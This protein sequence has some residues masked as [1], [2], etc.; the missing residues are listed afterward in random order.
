MPKKSYRSTKHKPAAFRLRASNN[1]GRSGNK[2]P[3]RKHPQNTLIVGIDFGTTFS[4]AAWDQSSDKVPSVLRYNS[5]GSYK[6]GNIP[7]ELANNRL[8]WFKLLLNEGDYTTP[9]ELLQR[10]EAK[11]LKGY[12]E[13]KSA[14]LAKLRTK[15]QAIPEGKTPFDLA[16]DYFRS[17]YKYVQS[18]IEKNIPALKGQIGNDGGVAIKCCLTV[19]AIWDDKAK[20][21]TKQAAIA[22]GLLEKQIYMIS[23]PEAAAVHCLTSLCEMGGDLKVG[24]VYVIVDCGGGTV[25]LIPYEVTSTSPLQVSE[26]TIGTGGLCGSTIL[27]RRFEDFMISRIGQ[28]AYDRM[29]DDD[30]QV[31]R[32][33]FEMEIKPN[34]KPNFLP[35]NNDDE[36]DDDNC[37]ICALPGVPDSDDPTVRVKKEK[38]KFSKNELKGIFEST[39]TEIAELVQKQVKMAQEATKKNVDGIILVGGFGSSQYLANWLTDSIRNKD[40]KEIKLIRPSDPAVAVVLGAVKHGVYMHRAGTG[41]TSQWGI[42]GSRRARYHYGIKVAEPF[43]PGHRHTKR[44]MDPHLGIPICIDP[45]KCRKGAPMREQVGIPSQFS[46]RCP[47]VYSEEAQKALLVFEQ[48]IYCSAEDAAP[49]YLEDLDIHPGSRYPLPLLTYKIDLSDPQSRRYFVK[50]PSVMSLSEFWLIPAQIL[51]KLESADLTFTTLVEGKVSGKGTKEYHHKE[52]GGE[53]LQAPMDG[54][55]LEVDDA[56]ARR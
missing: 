41:K 20:E 45:D 15:I 53:L 48:K 37:V 36:L 49:E 6:W 50:L 26:C 1:A 42:V 5:K 47:V 40:G 32:D 31:M 44:V 11:G 28:E 39:F 7:V 16:A 46:C 14:N 27:D 17:L 22:A 4:G 21:I 30:H 3:A 29:D 52:S 18:R 43:K 54:R 10:L 35:G 12:P 51:L 55:V 8:E 38:I 23:E 34:F 24:E 9:A 56:D 25:D 19:P 13:S 33:Y 2:D